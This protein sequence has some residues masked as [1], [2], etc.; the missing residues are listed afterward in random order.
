MSSKHH[1]HSLLPAFQIEEFAVLSPSYHW[2]RYMLLDCFS[3]RHSSCLKISGLVPKADWPEKNIPPTELQQLRQKIFQVGYQSRP[4]LLATT[5]RLWHTHLTVTCDLLWQDWLSPRS[6]W[7]VWSSPAAL[8]KHTIH[9]WGSS[10]LNYSLCRE[11]KTQTERSEAL[12]EM[13]RNNRGPPLLLR[14]FQ[15]LW[16]VKLEHGFGL[17]FDFIRQRWKKVAAGI[18]SS[19]ECEQFRKNG[20][21]LIWLRGPHVDRKCCDC[22]HFSSCPWLMS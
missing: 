5:C 18:R 2:T 9:H 10:C 11:H 12:F 3:V 14:C 15:L 20:V 22:H 17:A 16:L 19:S 13:K 7:E 8:Q 6:A 1:T 21:K 4:I